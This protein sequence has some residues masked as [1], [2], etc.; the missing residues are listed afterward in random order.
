MIRVD[1][2][3]YTYP[4]A[5]APTL[6]GAMVQASITDYERLLQEIAAH[7]GEVLWTMG[8]RDDAARLLKEAA[9]K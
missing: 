7:L 6:R 8:R 2:L 3:R 9:G 4:G 5:A 1:D